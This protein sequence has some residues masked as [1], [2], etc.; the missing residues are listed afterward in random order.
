MEFET[1]SRS[2]GEDELEHAA[3]KRL[4]VKPINT[5]VE[6]AYD[7]DKNRQHERS[8]S[9]ANLEFDNE[10]TGP[11]ALVAAA[12]ERKNRHSPILAISAWV[13]AF[14]VFVVVLVLLKTY[15]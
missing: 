5:S 4:I 9:S 14:I 12:S 3:A 1:N 6:P 8:G 7:P 13:S 2:S 11:A 15:Y 10:S